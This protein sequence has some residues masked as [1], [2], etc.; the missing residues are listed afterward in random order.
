M[1]KEPYD[2]KVAWRAEVLRASNLFIHSFFK[3][4]DDIGTTNL[5]HQTRLYTVD[6]QFHYCLKRPLVRFTM[7]TEARE[8]LQTQSQGVSSSFRRMT[9]VV[10]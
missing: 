4:L 3:H 8:E 7:S 1:Q 10:W 5:C 6:R 9:G 2:A